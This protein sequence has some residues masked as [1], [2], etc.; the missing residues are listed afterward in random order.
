MHMAIPKEIRH[1]FDFTE[2]QAQTRVEEERKLDVEKR[3]IEREDMFHFLCTAR[4]PDIGDFAL[5]IEDL[6]ADAN[7]LIVAGPDTSSTTVSGLF[8]HVTRH[9]ACLF[10]ISEGDP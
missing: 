1:Y 7:L 5:T 9:P 2:K 3:P 10:K 8:S 6:I 4:K